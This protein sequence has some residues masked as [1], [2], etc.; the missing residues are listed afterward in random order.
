MGEVGTTLWI[1]RTSIERWDGAGVDG[2]GGSL[3][4]VVDKNEKQHR[5]GRVKRDWL[6]RHLLKRIE[7]SIKCAGRT[8][9]KRVADKT[10]LM[11]ELQIMS[12]NQY[13]PKYKLTKWKI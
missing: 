2:L 9:N 3:S 12:K 10:D 7:T 11:A 13:L 4:Q 6:T 8:H 5:D 1:Q